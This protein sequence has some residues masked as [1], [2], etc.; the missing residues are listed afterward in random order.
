MHVHGK[1]DRHV[2]YG[3]GTIAVTATASL[4]FAPV[5]TT[6]ENWRNFL[7]CQTEPTLSTKQK[8]PARL[9]LLRGG[10]QGIDHNV[11]SGC[12]GGTRV[13][14]FITGDGHVFPRGSTTE[15]KEGIRWASGL[16]V[17]PEI[18]RFFAEAFSS[19]QA[20]GL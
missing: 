15:V 16:D 3:G 6:I 12:D 13:E 9:E 11:Y 19:Q 18:V 8:V 20:A 7:H 10:D 5:E 14:S 17:A 1:N 2:A 4:S